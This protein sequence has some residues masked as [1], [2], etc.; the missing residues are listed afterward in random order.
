MRF[1]VPRSL[2]ALYK[3]EK[4]GAVNKPYFDQEPLPDYMLRGGMNGLLLFALLF[5]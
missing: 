4:E 3:I 2:V 1:P 5:L